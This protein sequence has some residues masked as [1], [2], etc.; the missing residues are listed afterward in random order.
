M[1]TT[2]YCRCT[3]AYTDGGSSETTLLKRCEGLYVDLVMSLGVE[4]SPSMCN[5]LV[6]TSRSILFPRYVHALIYLGYLEPR[7]FPGA[8]VYGYQGLTAYAAH[9]MM[10]TGVPRSYSFMSFIYSWSE[11]A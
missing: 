5:A 7:T 3:Q 2:N 6:S 10:V 11:C 1:E 8:R 9:T 4:C